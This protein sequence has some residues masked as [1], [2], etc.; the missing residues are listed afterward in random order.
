[1]SPRSA[2]ND[3][4]QLR[5]HDAGEVD[6]VA[7]GNGFQAQAAKCAE[8]ARSERLAQCR[9]TG[10]QSQR[11]IRDDD[12]AGLGATQG[13]LVIRL[14]IGAGRV[15]ANDGES[16]GSTAPQVLA[17]ELDRATDD[18]HVDAGRASRS[19]RSF[20]RVISSSPGSEKPGNAAVT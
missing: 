17:A 4:D 9:D 2:A 16:F 13:D 10:V 7:L 8:L 20:A 5:K 6:A 1:M 11:Q 15:Q 14:G 12:G 18:H 3:V 19:S